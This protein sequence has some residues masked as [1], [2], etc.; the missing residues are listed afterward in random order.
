[1]LCMLL[2]WSANFTHMERLT[3]TFFRSFNFL[4]RYTKSFTILDVEGHLL[5]NVYY[6]LRG[7]S[8]LV[9]SSDPRGIA[10]EM[11]TTAISSIV[12]AL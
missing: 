1:M 11:F 7:L 3:Q 9:V 2:T 12:F 8:E 4:F 5:V 10:V 6:N